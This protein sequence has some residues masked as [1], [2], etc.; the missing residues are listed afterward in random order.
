L[1]KQSLKPIEVAR[2]AGEI[3]SDKQAAD[4]VVLDI[5]EV[6]SFADYFVICSGESDRQLNAIWQEIQEK[7]KQ[8][9]VIP[10]RIEGTADSGWIII[11]LGDVVVHIFSKD[12][13]N[14]YRLEELWHK[15]TPV[16]RIQ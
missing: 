10:N 2:K 6:S 5:R 15:A 16:L 7:L 4:I 9:G 1:D 12:L 11:D 13:R 8:D 3:A 14:Y